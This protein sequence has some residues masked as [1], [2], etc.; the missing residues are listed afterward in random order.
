MTDNV[1]CKCSPFFM[2]SQHSFKPL[3]VTFFVTDSKQWQRMSP[4]GWSLNRQSTALFV[5]WVSSIS[6]SVVRALKQAS[7][8]IPR[9]GVQTHLGTHESF[10]F[11]TD[12]KRWHWLSPAS[13]VAGE[14]P[15]SIGDPPLILLAVYACPWL[16][17]LNAPTNCSFF[18]AM[19]LIFFVIYLHVIYLH[20]IFIVVHCHCHM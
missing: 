2:V 6:G 5:Q 16:C 10:S 4:F 3:S 20:N 9:L 1:H 17:L 13:R 14:S 15:F 11:V 18:H 7:F 12:Q 8:H 19:S